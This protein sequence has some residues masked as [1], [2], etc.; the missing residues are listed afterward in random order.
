MANNDKGATWVSAQEEIINPYFGDMMLRCGN[1]E[2][3][4]ENNPN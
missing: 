3:T 4:I 2:Y 1:V